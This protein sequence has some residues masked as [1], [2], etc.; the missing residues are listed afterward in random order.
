[1]KQPGK[2]SKV[3]IGTHEKCT[4]GKEQRISCGILSLFFALNNHLL[5]LISA[6]NDAEMFCKLNNTNEHT[7]THTHQQTEQTHKWI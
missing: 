1:M 5:D 7:N 2:S 6:V 4:K 3:S